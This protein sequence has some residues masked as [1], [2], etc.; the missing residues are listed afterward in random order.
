M[1]AVQIPIRPSTNIAA[2]DYDAETQSLTITFKNQSVYRYYP[3]HPQTAQLL[4]Q[5]E[6]PGKFVNQ[7]IKQANFERL[8]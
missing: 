8:R 5:A 4:A 6:S 3:I 2:A 7:N 1:P